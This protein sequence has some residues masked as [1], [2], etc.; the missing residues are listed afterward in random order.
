MSHDPKEGCDHAGWAVS[1]CQQCEIER[2]RAEVE[3]LREALRDIVRDTDE[4]FGFASY[5][6][7]HAWA[8]AVLGIARAALSSAPPAKPSAL[9]IHG[10]WR[11]QTDS[12]RHVY[13]IVPLELLEA[14]E[15]WRGLSEEQRQYVIDD[16]ESAR[17]AD[18]TS[19]ARHRR[20]ALALLRA[21]AEVKP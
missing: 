2:L 1:K 20:A 15:A 7:A 18:C 10:P 9:S 17:S 19:L 6:E 3:R 21:A 11:D 5:D 16:L 8:D 14:L 4:P 13:A 12:D